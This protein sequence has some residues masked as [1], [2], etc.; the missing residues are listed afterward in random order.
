M[1]FYYRLTFIALNYSRLL[2]VAKISPLLNMA[3]FLRMSKPSI[4]L[5]SGHYEG[6]WK[7]I[8]RPNYWLR[9]LS[10]KSSLYIVDALKA[11]PWSF[12]FSSLVLTLYGYSYINIIKFIRNS[13]KVTR[14]NKFMFFP[15]YLTREIADIFTPYASKF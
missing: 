6:F 12:I 13:K 4:T 1:L 8:C 3:P 5:A 2:E 10:Y 15:D 7:H 11:L 9:D 14:V